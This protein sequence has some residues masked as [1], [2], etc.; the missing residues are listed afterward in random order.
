MCQK[1]YKES[2]NISL[3]KSI[4]DELHMILLS[5]IFINNINYNYWV[6]IS[7]FLTNKIT[8]VKADKDKLGSINAY[9]ADFWVNV[10]ILKKVILN[11]L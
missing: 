8:Y 10:E 1:N 11:C 6:K 4:H 5:F 7:P 2:Y 9:H 3:N